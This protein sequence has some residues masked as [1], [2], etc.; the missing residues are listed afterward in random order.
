MITEKHNNPPPTV[1][2]AGL[3]DWHDMD[4]ALGLPVEEVAE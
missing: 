3:L 4:E 2:D 1:V